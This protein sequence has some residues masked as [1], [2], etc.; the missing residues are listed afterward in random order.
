[1]INK[2][3]TWFV[4]SSSNPNQFSMTLKGLL[5]A[6]IGVIMY[7]LHLLNVPVSVEQVTEAIGMITGFIGSIAFVIGLVRKT[8]YFIKSKRDS[9]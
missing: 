2:F 4:T 3:L 1:M 8:Y 9:K 7:I 5:I 6:N